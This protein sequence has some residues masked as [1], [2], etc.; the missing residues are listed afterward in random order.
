MHHPDS[1]TPAASAG[2]NRRPT[3]TMVS[4]IPTIG[5]RRSPA[6]RLSTLVAVLTIAAACTVRLVSD[7]DD[8]I[9][10]RV[11]AFQGKVDAYLLNPAGDFDSFFADAMSDLNVIKARA[12]AIDKNERTTKEIENLKNALENMK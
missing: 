5:P 8:V 7:Y 9:D 2:N 1:R 4:Q 6:G 11:T 10:Q 3:R 12:E